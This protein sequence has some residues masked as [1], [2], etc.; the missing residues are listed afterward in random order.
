MPGN[1]ASI[2]LDRSGDR[3]VERVAAL[4]REHFPSLPDSVASAPGRVNLIGEHTDYNEGFVLPM[5]IGLRTCVAIGPSE[6]GRWHFVTEHDPIPIT[7]EQTQLGNEPD[8]NGRFWT[9]YPRGVIAGFLS[10]GY[11]IRPLCLAVASDVPVGA[12]LSSS[13]ALEVAVASA[14]EERLGVTLD[15]M[16]KVLLCQRAEHE[17][18]G[19]PC[20]LMDQMVSVFSVPECA[21]FVDCRTLEV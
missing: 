19:V 14:L 1:G 9:A 15:P 20:G 13:A 10:R 11:E 16:D 8:G 12:G 2:N 18:A 3:L 6:D 21:L 5:A 17:F 7:H 4:Y